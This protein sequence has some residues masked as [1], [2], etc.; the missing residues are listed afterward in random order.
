MKIL[1]LNIYGGKYYDEIIS[2][3]KQNEYDIICFQEVTGG[4]MGFTDSDSFQ[5]LRNDL[6][7]EAE[8]VIST[9]F[10]GDKNSY[11]GNAIF[12]KNSLIPGNKKEI[13]LYPF[14]ETKLDET[15]FRFRPRTAISLDFQI[16][17]KPI[18]IINTQL[19]WSL[20]PE[21]TQIK[22]EVGQKLF[23]FV[24]EIK[25]DFILMGDFNLESN[26]KVVHQFDSLAQNLIQMHNIKNTLNPRTHRAAKEIFPK[27]LAVDFVFIT[28]GIKAKEF[29]LLD[30]FDLSD[31]FGLSLAFEV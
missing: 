27:G 29:K 1:N 24:K 30:N 13:F 26:N 15:D 12:Y 14:S 16:N 8:I 23:N 21:T 28:P 22:E 5:N 6:G 18:T 9:N 17:N 20:I 10:V 4:R 7:M 11:D 2:F 19:A 3:L 31:H 25:N